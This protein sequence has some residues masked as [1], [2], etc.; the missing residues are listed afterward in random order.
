MALFHVCNFLARSPLPRCSAQ[1]ILA[2]SSRIFCNSWPAHFSFVHRLLKY[3]KSNYESSKLRHG[4]WYVSSLYMKHFAVVKSI[5]DISTFQLYAD[6]KCVT[7]RIFFKSDAVR[8]FRKV[9]STID[10]RIGYWKLNFYN[11]IIELLSLSLWHSSLL[12]IIQDS[13]LASK[14]RNN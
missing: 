8:R 1:P 9:D 11:V 3:T 10:A 12:V 5:H 2:Q 6:I 4:C 13:I 7:R 14:R